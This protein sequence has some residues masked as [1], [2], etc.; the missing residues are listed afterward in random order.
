[1]DRVAAVLASGGEDGL[2]D[3]AM[4]V[5]GGDF[6]VGVA[7]ERADVREIAGGMAELK[8]QGRVR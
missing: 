2:R 8:R 1:M 6:K 7:F 3:Q 5:R 4:Q